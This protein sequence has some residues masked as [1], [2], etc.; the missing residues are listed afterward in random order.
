MCANG[1]IFSPLPI[2]S[3]TTWQQLVQPINNDNFNIN[4]GVLETAHSIFRSWRSQA[5]SDAFWSIIKLVH[6]KFLA[7]YF[8]LFQLTIPRLLETPDP[9]LAQTM[10]VLVELFYDL[11]CQDLAP[12]FEDSHERFFAAETGF[13]MQLMEW[14]PPQLQTDV[15]ILSAPLRRDTESLQ[16]DEPTPSIPSRIRTGILEIA[17]V[18]LF[19]LSSSRIHE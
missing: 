14:N 3:Y 1:P 16:P 4:L 10:A 15:R 17:E 7:P 9:L 2:H 18:R 6:S 12:E 5:R 19:V 8:V 11:T 13:F